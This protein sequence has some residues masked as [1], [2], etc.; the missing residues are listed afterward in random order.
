MGRYLITSALPYING[1]KHLGNLIGS[2]LPADVYARYLRQ[3]GHEVLF[4]SGTDEHGT[5]AEL[6]AA[7]ENIPVDIYCK[8]MYETQKR[9]Y[10]D[11][12]LSF[13]YFGRS[14]SQKNHE[15]T[16]EI[17]QKLEVNGLITEGKVKQIFSIQ[18]NRFLPD[19][20][21]IGQCPYCEYE[22][23]RGDQCDGCGRLLEATDLRSSR[24]A[25]TPDSPLEIREV[26]NLYFCLSQ[27]QPRLEEW[28]NSCANNWPLVTSSIAHKWF[29]EGLQDRC[30]TR[31]IHWGISVPKEGFTEKVF[32][33]WFDAPNAYIS[34]TQ[35]WA[36]TYSVDWKRW[37][38]EQSNDVKYVQFMAKDNVPFHAVFWPGVLI[39]ANEN[40]KLVD[41]IKGFS[42]L[43]YNGGKFSTSQQR[44][45]FTDTALDLFPADYWRYYLLT[46][47]PES[48]DSD[49][50]F[51]GFA[52]TINK[53][54]ADVLGNFVSRFEALLKR[55]WDGCI[56]DFEPDDEFAL[57][58]K[59][60]K[61]VRDFEMNLESLSY[62]KAMHSLRCLWSLGNE[63]FT[64]TE[65]WK[66]VKSNPDK[67]SSIIVASYC[68]LRLIAVISSPIIPETSKRLFV[69]L[70]DDSDPASFSINEVLQFKKPLR[71]VKLEK[72]FALIQKITPEVVQELTNRFS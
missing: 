34:I 7:Q 27:L 38:K 30:I 55:Y 70:G 17:F 10:Q 35:E 29:Q 62:R 12:Q 15:L 52:A 33:V 50:V 46:I 31:D 6:A 58:E 26:S 41:V 63:Y 72:S 42:W 32:Y 49:F 13:D 69:F 4:I 71:P 53:D 39:G 11:F 66:L 20:Y 25:I 67:A 60:T 54:L 56:P 48:N 16:K 14:S 57:H 2:L 8:K 24:S 23:A 51:S 5:P 21:V 9:I 43:T 64:T 47:V 61:I 68:L 22:L 44:G 40:F 1:V 36:E 19:R 18:D 3:R 65:P 37:W 28:V 59:C 45:I